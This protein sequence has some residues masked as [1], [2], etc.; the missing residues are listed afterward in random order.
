MRILLATLLLL[1]GCAL[2]AADPES[3]LLQGKVLLQTDN[4]WRGE[5]V[6]D[7][8]VTV[9][10]GVT[11]TL[12]PGTRVRFI[13]KD[14]D[15]DGLGDATIIVKGRLIASG[16][17]QQPIQFRSAESKPVP[18]D[19][20]EIRSDFAQELRFDW[21]EFRDS[22]YTL[23]AHFTRGHLK[24]SHI[25]S[26]IDGCRLGRSQFLVQ[27]NL[28]EGNSGKGINFRDSEVTLVDNII[29]DN[30]A[31]IFLFEKPGKSIIARNNL[32][33]NGLNLQ[34]GDFFT[35]DVSIKG[36]WWGSADPEQ[37]DRGIYDQLDDNELGRVQTEA[38]SAWLHDAGV[39]YSAQ[40]LRQWKV[41]T[42]GFVDSSPILVDKNIVFASWDGSLRAVDVDGKILWLADTGDVIDGGLLAVDDKIYLQNWSRQF[43]SVDQATG[44]VQLLYHYPSSPADDHRQAGLEKTEEHILL[45][46]W[47]GMLYAFNRTDMTLD[48]QY[49]AGM[50]LRAV[51]LVV[52]GRIYQPSGNST[53]SVLD[54]R[55]EFM[56]MQKFEAPLL[57][58]PF[59]L[60]EKIL[61]LD[62]AGTLTAM[63]LEGSIL[64]RTNLNQACFYSTPLVAA[65]SLFVATAAGDLWK[66]DPSN[67]QVIW[68]RSL[69]KSIYAPP[70]SSSAGLLIGDNSG[71]LHLIDFDSGRTL[72]VHEVEGAIQSQVLVTGNR[73]YFGSRDQN[74]HALQI[75]SGGSPE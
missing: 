66:L 32:Y 45:P 16:T 71:I 42:G 55:G 26:N 40:F 60:A 50:P 36:N 7:G 5:I 10:Q 58:S 44:E 62:K 37:I 22:A 49:D 56:S 27:Y 63:N 67:G 53:L 34:L 47:N 51:P 11:L 46:G 13:R 61:Q 25:H 15:R 14:Q 4:L 59:G 31:G 21:C 52:A 43:Y 35:N 39:R 6:V 2:P 41:P 20:L 73:L 24:N 48:W 28:I 64:W 33:R 69:G 54:S 68:N 12:A 19:W 65:H 9:A 74:L 17:E 18:G 29:R 75:I 3:V 57:T 8:E 70:V 38:A 30:R 23:H 72:A 1:S